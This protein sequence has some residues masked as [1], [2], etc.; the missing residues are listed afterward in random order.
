MMTGKQ[1]RVWVEFNRL[2]MDT[3]Q[4]IARDFL[5][6]V[7]GKR[8]IYFKGLEEAECDKLQQ[9][10]DDIVSV[11][12]EMGRKTGVCAVCGR[13]LED[14]KS[15]TQG[16]GPVCAKRLTKHVLTGAYR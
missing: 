6:H 1:H 11:F 4:K 13:Y 3:S 12:G 14:P 5:E 2:Q 16:I 15:I 8:T 7:T 9:A 10:F